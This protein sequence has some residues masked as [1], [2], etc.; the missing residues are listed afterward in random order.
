MAVELTLKVELLKVL[1]TGSVLGHA[2]FLE[3]LTFKKIWKVFPALGVFDP[4][5]PDWLVWGFFF[6]STK[7]RED[8]SSRMRGQ[9]RTH[10]QISNAQLFSRYANGAVLSVSCPRAF[11]I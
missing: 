4:V 6:T 9:K 10:A 3:I 1:K 7:S 5:E 8:W 2:W 11:C